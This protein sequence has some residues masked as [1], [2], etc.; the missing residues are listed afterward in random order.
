M[1]AAN[2]SGSTLLKARTPHQTGATIGAWK[3]PWSSKEPLLAVTFN[4]VSKGEK[5]PGPIPAFQLTDGSLVL[6]TLTFNAR[7]PP[8]GTTGVLLKTPLKNESS[9]RTEIGESS[10]IRSSGKV[11][12]GGAALPWAG[13]TLIAAKAFSTAAYSAEEAPYRAATALR[14]PLRAC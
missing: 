8:A 3:S 13:P 5:N 7:T 1:V 9:V 2:C 4:G 6:A 12:T 11:T 10:A 14:A